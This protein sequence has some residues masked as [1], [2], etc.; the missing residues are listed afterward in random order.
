MRAQVGFG[1][2]AGDRASRRRRS[3]RLAG[4]MA[5]LAG[6]QRDTR[7]QGDCPARHF[8]PQTRRDQNTRV[9]PTT[10]RV[11]AN[12]G[13]STASGTRTANRLP[14]MMPGIE[15]MS[16]GEHR[17]VDRPQHPVAETGDQCQ[18]HCVRDVG[19]DDARHRQPR[20]QQEQH[21]HADRA[22]ADRGRSSPAHPAQ[23][24]SQP[25]VSMSAAPKRGR[26]DWLPS[27]A[28]VGETAAQRR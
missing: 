8:G 16:S 11:T 4:R 14:R 23:G 5:A 7:E 3:R 20:K 15:P 26:D 24:R 6:R 18:R 13:L 12:T 17:N 2:E 19:A 28:A 25:S 22:G 1:V 21:G 10:A 9:P 27:R